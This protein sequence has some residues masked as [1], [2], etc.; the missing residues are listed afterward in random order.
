MSL[1]T[2][3]NISLAEVGLLGQASRAAFV[4]GSI[5]VGWTVVTPAELGLPSKY[6]AGN[7]F[8]DPNSDASAILLKQGNSYVVAFRGTDGDDDVLHYPE[9]L[10]GSYIHNY[11]PLLNR[12]SALAL[13]GADFAFTG[14]SLGG[15]ATNLM[16]AIAGSA[17]GGAFAAATFVAFASPN[18]RAAQGILNLGFENDLIYKAIND[19]AD[20]PSSL[21]NLVLAS[22]EYMAGN[23]NGRHPF[24]DYAHS[25][26]FASTAIVQIGK[27]VFYDLMGSCPR[28]WCNNRDGAKPLASAPHSAV[29]SE[30]LAV[31]IDGSSVKVGLLHNLIRGT[32]R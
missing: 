29:A 7:Y 28:R 21:D 31:V 32:D 6:R 24:D 9:L 11:D 19:Y 17:F 30:R 14:A 15:G 12:L 1:L 16:A 25:F 4:G 26:A 8:T 13:S 20:F 23:Y 2:G 10:N 22:R 27:S 3:F 5:P 18:I